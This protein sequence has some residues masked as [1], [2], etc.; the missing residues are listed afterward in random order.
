MLPMSD[1]G[2]SAETA[3]LDWMQ[4]ITAVAWARSSPLTMDG[5]AAPTSD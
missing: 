2:S 3:A 4:S 5:A 1:S